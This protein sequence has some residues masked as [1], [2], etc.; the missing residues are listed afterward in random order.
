MVHRFRFLPLLALAVALI[1]LG[2]I[3]SEST[4]N[5]A[6]P[7][8]SPGEPQVVS[9]LGVARIQGQDVLVD[10]L[11]AV[12][13]GADAHTAAAAALA[14]QGARPFQS[15]GLGSKGFTLTGL[16]WDN[17][18]VSQNYNASNE[19]SSLNGAGQTALTNTHSTWD[20]VATSSFDID[21]GALTDRCPSLVK[22]CQG[23][24]LFDGFNDVAW[25]R[26]GGRTLGVTW[27]GT[28]TDE[29]DMALN[30]RYNWDDDGSDI[31][32]ETVFL[33][34]NGHV[35][36][37]GHSNDAGSVLLPSYHGVD[38]DLGTDDEEG[39]TFL[40]DSAITGNVSGTITDGTNP[41]AGATVV[42][43]GTSLQA[44]TA[45]DGAYTISGV[46]DPVTYTVTASADGL[47]S[48]TISRLT[49]DGATAA[50]FTLTPAGDGDDGGGP[51]PCRGKNKNDPGC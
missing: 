19:P 21:F 11:V 20:G 4:V 30:T 26:M 5:A 16:K 37:L 29:A 42:L 23:P 38:R 18:P 8:G 27:Y 35:V 46:P 40:Y 49:V 15:A 41:V 7:S 36:G 12:P 10:V 3:S 47:D 44:T 43:E 32:V 39:A 50:D 45:A 9:A 25:L 24:Q 2:I 31:D 33:H 6:V 14:D 1:A 28:T 34:E 13:P 22:E 17:L 51:P 48:A